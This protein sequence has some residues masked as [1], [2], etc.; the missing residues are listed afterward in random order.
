MHAKATL[1]ESEQR[2][3]VLMEGIPQPVWCETDVGHWSWAGRQWTAY[4][5]MSDAASQ[6]L[7]WLQA[8]HPDDRKGAGDAWKRPAVA[9]LRDADYRIRRAAVGAWR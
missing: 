2:Q 4:T 6:D 9:G 1:R 7:G 3:R 5:G 8:V